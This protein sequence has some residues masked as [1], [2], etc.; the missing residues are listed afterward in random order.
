LGRA[1][2]IPRLLNGYQIVGDFK[3]DLFFELPQTDLLLPELKLVARDIRSGRPIRERNVQRQAGSIPRISRI[4][5][6]S[7]L[8]FAL[9]ILACG[10]GT[11]V[12]INGTLVIH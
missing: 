11:V 10:T 1:V 3:L 2:S 5:L 9:G 4:N 8:L 12:P 7:C 6:K